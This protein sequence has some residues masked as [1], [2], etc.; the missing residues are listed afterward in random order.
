MDNQTVR[1]DGVIWYISKNGNSRYIQP[2]CPKHHLRLKNH[3]NR[4]D[5]S[6]DSL[7][8]AE[9]NDEYIF[10]RTI[11]AEK[12]Y[13]L[14]K[15]D[16]KIFKQMKVLNLDDEAIPLA[17]SK[18]SSKDD[19]FFVT[20][21]LTESKV[22]KRLVVYAGEKGRKEKSQIFIEP[23]IKRLA[24]DQKD[25]HPTEV[26]LELTGTFDD[27]SSVTINKTKIKNE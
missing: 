23:E 18:I 13:I 25:M 4:A 19:K 9:C 27:G 17:E 3:N 12:Q 16:S 10:P 1:V 15:I 6:T 26:F 24:F 14:D 7:V 22:G 20:A 5:Y 21:I 8:C 2:L 11:S